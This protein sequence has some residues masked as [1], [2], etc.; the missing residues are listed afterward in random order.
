VY[1]NPQPTNGLGIAGFITSL[2]G[3]VSCGLLAPVGLILSLFALVKRPRGFAIAGTVIGAIGC[4]VLVAWSLGFVLAMIGVGAGVKEVANHVQTYTTARDVAAQ[5]EAK[6][7]T[8][9][10]LPPDADAD[11]IAGATTDAWGT[12]YRYEA[13]GAAGGYALLSAGRDRQFE[14]GDDVRMTADE[15]TVRVPTQE[16]LERMGQEAAK[17]GAASDRPPAVERE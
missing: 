9:R 6:R 1:V 11:A 7:G 13:G 12:P 8:D 10:S 2:V 17:Q 5:I 16:E 14:T 4:V 3:I 15:L